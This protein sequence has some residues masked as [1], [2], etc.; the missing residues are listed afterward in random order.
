MTEFIVITKVP[1]W[2]SGGNLA[3][4]FDI[5][6]QTEHP[7]QENGYRGRYQTAIDAFGFTMAL[8]LHT[9]VFFPGEIVITNNDGR[10]IVGKGRKPDKW[11]VEYETFKNIDDAI[12]RA[13]EV[14]V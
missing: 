4:G 1:D 8:Q 3:S 9:T 5:A 11:D 7:G 12:K 14:G 2:T 6:V 13:Q 10:E